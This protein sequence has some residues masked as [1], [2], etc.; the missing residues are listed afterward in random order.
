MLS[1][2]IHILRENLTRIQPI[3]LW[4]I[5]L[6]LAYR[7]GL[8][9]YYKLDP[10]GMWTK[11]FQKWGYPVWFRYLIG[12]L[13]LGGA[14]LLIIPK[15]RHF[16]GILLAIIMIGALITRLVNGTSTGDALSITWDAVVYLYFAS[17]HFKENKKNS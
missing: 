6:W 10:E 16:G 5:A 14:L 15:T 2:N 4:L 12:L 9:G 13:E 11:A 8:M 17:Y 1:K 7:V 3:L